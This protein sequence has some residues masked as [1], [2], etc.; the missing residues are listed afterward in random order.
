MDQDKK[1]VHDRALALVRDAFQQ[2]IA[3]RSVDLDG[4][5][6]PRPAELRYHSQ[7]EL[8]RDYWHAA[9]AVATFAVNM[10]LITP[11]DAQEILRGYS[12]SLD[13]SEDEIR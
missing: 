2:A 12:Q 9:G 5:N 8:F 7:L 4:V 6:G 10:A 11:A 3:V 13:A 1:G